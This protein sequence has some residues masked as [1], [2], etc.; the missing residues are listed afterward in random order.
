M[1]VWSLRVFVYFRCISRQQCLLNITIQYTVEATKTMETEEDILKLNDGGDTNTPSGFTCDGCG[2]TFQKPIMAS[3]LFDERVQEYLAC[4][5]CMT[6]VDSQQTQETVEE[7]PEPPTPI[8]QTRKTTLEK[9]NIAGC[10]HSFG[11]LKKRERD[12]PFPEECLTC[13][14][15]ID[16]LTESA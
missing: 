2:R 4:P 10:T 16:C 13:S 9:E 7:E 3:V 8:S 15:M 11:Y 1:S 6:K 12:K 14:K 5:R